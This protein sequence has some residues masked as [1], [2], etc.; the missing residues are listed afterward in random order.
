L[1]TL[2]RFPQY[3]SLDG[4]REYPARGSDEGRDEKTKKGNLLGSHLWAI[5][6][7]SARSSAYCRAGLHTPLVAG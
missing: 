1:L 5:P 4:C 7:E 2:G 3:P 6:C